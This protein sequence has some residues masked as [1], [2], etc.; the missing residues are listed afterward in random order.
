MTTDGVFAH[1]YREA[2]DAFLSTGEG[3]ARDGI[4]H[5]GRG[6]NGGALACDLAWRN[7]EAAAQL[8]TVSGTHGIEGLAGGACQTHWLGTDL[9][10]GVGV[11][12]IH[13]INP[14]GFAWRRRVD[15]ENIDVNR[16]FIDFTQPLPENPAYEELAGSLA[17]DIWDEVS[18]RISR[19]AWRE[20]MARD[21]EVAFAEAIMRGQYRH[22]TGLYYGGQ[23]PCWSRQVF[24]RIVMERL[25]MAKR[26][27]LIDL[28]SGL[29][30]RGEVQLI[31]R[32]EDG[33]D[34]LRRA[35]GWFGER[36]HRPVLGDR[37]PAQVSGAL[38]TALERWL[39]TAE[40]TAV[41]LKSAPFRRTRSS[42]PCGRIIGCTITATRL[43]AR[44]GDQKPDA[45]DVLSRRSRLAASA[46]GRRRRHL[47]AG[48]QGPVV[49]TGASHPIARSPHRRWPRLRNRDSVA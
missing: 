20:F 40:I 6:P 1:N 36:V 18:D 3:Y 17:P 26:I 10:D 5:P 12:H 7:P 19:I 21:G 35:R 37:V 25:G 16:N 41:A 15:H 14:Y 13:A 22:P 43:A 30:A 47:R 23:A 48:A 45:G 42:M 32:H 39:P 34:A 2:R 29:G 27:A 33:S 31:C 49:V 28:H 11:L 4:P 24:K 9:P 44:A 38:R 8:V 46:S